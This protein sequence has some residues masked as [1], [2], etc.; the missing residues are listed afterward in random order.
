MRRPHE[1][2]GL[3]FFLFSLLFFGGTGILEKSPRFSGAARLG[4]SRCRRPCS[5]RVG[6][7][8]RGLRPCLTGF[9]RRATSGRRFSLRDRILVPFLRP[10]SQ[11]L[12][13]YFIPFSFSPWTIL[14]LARFLAYIRG[15]RRLSVACS[16]VSFPLTGQNPKCA[17]RINAS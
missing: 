12:N 15:F 11:Q 17:G 7:A 8:P 16:K 14:C 2:A 3:L 9:V 13:C 4:L 1:H 6:L 10:P 5:R